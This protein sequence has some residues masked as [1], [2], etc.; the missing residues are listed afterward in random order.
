[1]PQLSC[2]RE[3]GWDLCPSQ[4]GA[5]DCLCS[6]FCPIA[7]FYHVYCS[8]VGSVDSNSSP[9]GVTA[10]IRR[11]MTEYSKREKWETKF[12]AKCVHLDRRPTA[13]GPLQGAWGRTVPEGLVPAGGC[14]E[15]CVPTHVPVPSRMS[16]KSA[17]CM[18]PE[19]ATLLSHIQLSTWELSA[20][21][22]E[23]LSVSLALPSIWGTERY[24]RIMS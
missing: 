12:L 22:M 9:R 15:H 23:Q 4:C 16:P 18:K 20:M 19:V 11:N 13:W 6:D 1:M 14:H 21:I 5:E 3:P 8:P 24:A 17:C 10:E 2:P 7:P